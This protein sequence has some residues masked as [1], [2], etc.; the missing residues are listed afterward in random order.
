M[1]GADFWQAHELQLEREDA[2]ADVLRTIAAAG[3][4][5]EADYLAAELGVPY[6]AVEQRTYPLW[7]GQC[8]PF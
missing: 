3:M 7:D 8:A 4:R 5:V 6:R 2:I 1:S